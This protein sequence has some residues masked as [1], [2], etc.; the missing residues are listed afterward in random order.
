MY[1]APYIMCIMLSSLSFLARLLLYFNPV[2]YILFILQLGL[3]KIM[4]YIEYV[5]ITSKKY[6]Y[7]ILPVVFSATQ[8]Q[9]NMI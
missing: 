6:D 3:S 9:W 7:N 5:L 8:L 4:S 1:S 2:V